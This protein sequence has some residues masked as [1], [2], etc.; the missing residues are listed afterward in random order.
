MDSQ[1][2]ENLQAFKEFDVLRYVLI[3]HKCFSR[4]SSYFVARRQKNKFKFQWTDCWFLVLSIRNLK[5]LFWKIS[6]WVLDPGESKG[7]TEHCSPPSDPQRE[8]P[9]SHRA[10]RPLVGPGWGREA[11]TV[12]A[13]S[14][15]LTTLGVK[16]SSGTQLWGPHKAVRFT[17]RS[18]TEK[19]EKNPLGLLAGGGGKGIV[20]EYTSAFCSSAPRRSQLTRA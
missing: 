17:S 14:S 9:A 12:I 13:G 8:R 1:K 5:L 3:K 20:L 10:E 6:N 19:P 16:D 4:S 15:V 18:P 7:H 11:R 2:Q